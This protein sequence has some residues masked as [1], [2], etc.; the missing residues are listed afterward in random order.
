MKPSITSSM[1]VNYAEMIALTMWKFRRW[2]RGSVHEVRASVKVVNKGTFLFSHK[3]TRRRDVK[4][5]A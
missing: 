1:A 4:V 2:K 3:V 5:R